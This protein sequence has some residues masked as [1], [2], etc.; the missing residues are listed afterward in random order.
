MQLV[1]NQGRGRIFVVSAPAGTGKTTLVQM[2]VSE[3]SSVKESV[4]VTTRPPRGNEI[5]GVHYSF[6]TQDAFEAGIAS[7]DFLEHAKVFGEY[8]GTSQSH[9]EREIEQG[10]HVVLVIDTQGALQLM[11]KIS[12]VFIFI[13]P[14]SIEELRLRLERRQTETPEKIAERLTWAEQEMEVGKQYDYEFVNEDLT[15]AYEVLRSIVI[16]EQHKL[17]P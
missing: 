6:V 4:S 16:A 11:K 7:G 3:F 5:P 10:N 13:R 9:L 1:G 15:V 17:T 2:L 12:A 8:Y 14:P